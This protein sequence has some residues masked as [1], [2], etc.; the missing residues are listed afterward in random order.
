MLLGAT[1]DRDRTV[2][3]GAVE[4]LGLAADE[5][6]RRRGVE[7]GIFDG[8]GVGDVLCQEEQR[9]VGV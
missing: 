9:D 1:H 2:W 5:R 3:G 8:A 7:P 4:R 6:D